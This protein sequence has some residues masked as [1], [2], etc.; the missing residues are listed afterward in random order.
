LVKIGKLFAR[1]NLSDI[2]KISGREPTLYPNLIPLIQNLRGNFPKIM[3]STNGTGSIQLMQDLIENGVTIFAIPLHTTDLNK[4]ILMSGLSPNHAKLYFQKIFDMIEYLSQ[5]NCEL[6]II[7]VIMKTL[8]DTQHDT[9][10]FLEICRKNHALGK[11]FGIN[12]HADLHRT[13]HNADRREHLFLGCAADAYNQLRV[14]LDPIR[15]FIQTQSF[16][17]ESYSNNFSLRTVTVY[18]LHDGTKVL[19]DSY[20]QS[21]TRYEFCQ[22]CDYQKFCQEGPYSNGWEIRPDLKLQICPMRDDLTIDFSSPDTIKR[23]YFEG[24]TLHVDR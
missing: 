5:Q 23:I 16:R 3:V 12:Y 21:H 6:H 4:F 14:D 10:E 8:N 1:N 13:D 15:H 18:Q 7:R 9:E 11:I 22:S 2:L 17:T 24:G 20:E 19:L